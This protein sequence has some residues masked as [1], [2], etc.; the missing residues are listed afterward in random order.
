MDSWQ[1]HSDPPTQSAYKA[2][3]LYYIGSKSINSA[4]TVSLGTTDLYYC[5]SEDAVHI[6]S[7]D[8]KPY[9]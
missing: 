4:S 1:Q 3:N 6:M 7:L 5:V 9:Q 2:T 8:S